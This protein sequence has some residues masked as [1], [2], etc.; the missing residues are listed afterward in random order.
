[1]FSWIWLNI[2]VRPIYNL[3]ILAYWPFKDLGLAI[4]L[5]T[6]LIRVAL[7]PLFQKQ[8]R[9][10]KDLAGLQEEI[11]KIREKYSQDPG[12]IQQATMA[13]YQARGANPLSGCLPMLIQLPI[14][15]AL[16]HVF[17]FRLAQ[18]HLSLLYS[19]VPHP[20]TL[21]ILAFGFIDLGRPDF[22]VLP[23]LV[24]ITQF[25]VG[26][27]MSSRSQQDKT[28]KRK[29]SSQP[30]QMESMNRMM[31]YFMPVF[32]TMISFSLPSAIVLY[33]V[34]SNILSIVQYYFFNKRT[35]QVT[36]KNTNV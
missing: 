2:L 35:P 24:G 11:K 1:M 23:Y 12:K 30:I 3:L 18:E 34:V 16:Y 4:I 27:I 26:K 6:I 5:V 22:Y 31:T 19:F 28:T 10:Q 7:Y 36:I 15:I 17:R 20:P 14:F 32:L 21:S 25:L 13:L 8:M 29:D 9:S 33:L